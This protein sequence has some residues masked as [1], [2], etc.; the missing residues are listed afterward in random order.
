MNRKRANIGQSRASFGQPKHVSGKLQHAVY[1]YVSNFRAPSGIYGLQFVRACA[2]KN[3]NAR[4]KK[5]QALSQRP[6]LK[7]KITTM[8]KN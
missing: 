8:I 4:Y 1:Q 2:R 6:G 3:R 5:P 7:Q